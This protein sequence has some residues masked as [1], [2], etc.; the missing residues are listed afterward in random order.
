M[1]QLKDIRELQ[2]LAEEKQMTVQ[3]LVDTADRAK[4]R[5]PCSEELRN[6]IMYNYDVTDVNTRSI[7]DMSNLCNG[8]TVFNQDIGEWDVSNVESMMKMFEYAYS[9]DKD[10]SKWDVSSVTEMRQMFASA[11][12]F[13]K[14]ISGWNVEKAHSMDYMF[15]GATAFIKGDYF[16]KTI[17][18]WAKQRNLTVGELTKVV[19]GK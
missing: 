17:S 10:I 14:D 19:L 5:G 18:S 4:A 2:K 3:E 8:V 6:L 9:F 7:R 15:K 16:D 12:R 11:P 1:K 13:N